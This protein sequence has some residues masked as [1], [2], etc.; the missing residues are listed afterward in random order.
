MRTRA[1]PHRCQDVSLV[2][3]GIRCA[4]LLDSQRAPRASPPLADVLQALEDDRRAN[5]RDGNSVEG[6][7]IDAIASLGLLKLEG[8]SF[9]VNRVVLACRVR[10]VLSSDPLPVNA[11]AQT[12]SGPCWSACG[13]IS[14]AY[15]TPKDGSGVQS[16]EQ[17]EEEAGA[18]VAVP[19]RRS[20]MTAACRPGGSTVIRTGQARDFALVDVRKSLP[21]P[22]VR[23]NIFG[24]RLC[25]A[26][27][28]IFGDAVVDNE[29]PSNT[30]ETEG[31]RWLRDRNQKDLDVS[32]DGLCVILGGVGL[33][34]LAGWI[35]EYPVVYCCQSLESE[36]AEGGNDAGDDGNCLAML[37]LTVYSVRLELG[38]TDDRRPRD[39]SC[40][41]EAFSFSVPE[42][43]R[44]ESEAEAD[45]I[46]NSV[47]VEDRSQAGVARL[48]VLVADFV[49]RIERRITRHRV[50][51]GQRLQLQWLRE[52]S[53]SKRT[54]TLDRVAL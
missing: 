9:L 51:C 47:V 50:N 41:F 49:D 27:R 14:S 20:A 22:S 7:D 35:L 44:G 53:V 34:G 18:S 10:E 4:V 17:G 26:L 45:P 2:A 36:Q 43:V 33:S 15:A 42:M 39:S 37:P 38:R 31:R 40:S 28:S 25:A 19:P 21:A 12:D 5:C 1:Y 8:S 29:A 46:A 52:L 54:E 16:T 32:S 13:R 48:H 6:G 3:A 30:A 11:V 23:T 24:P